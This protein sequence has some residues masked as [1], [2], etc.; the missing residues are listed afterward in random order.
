MYVAGRSHPYKEPCTRFM[1]EVARGKIE[2]VADVEI[3]QEILYR[4]YHVR[5]LE[6]GFA[7]FDA[8]LQVVPLFH[9]VML[10]DL[11][12]S[13]RLL[14][15]YPALSPRDA[16]HAAVMLRVGIT[17]VVSYDRHFDGVEGIRREEPR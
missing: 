17:T 3:L 8:F 11:L 14:S 15:Q 7:L 16:V 4:F 2:A 6:K 10:E 5:Q 12:R 13:K 1:R 9:A